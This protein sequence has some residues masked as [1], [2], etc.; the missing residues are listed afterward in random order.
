MVKKSQTTCSL[1]F[2]LIRES[3]VSYR[4]KIYPLKITAVKILNTFSPI[5]YQLQSRDYFHVAGFRKNV[6]WIKLLGISKK[7]YL[8]RLMASKAKLKCLY[9]AVL[10]YIEACLPFN[11]M[12]IATLNFISYINE[13]VKND[14][15]G[16]F[17]HFKRNI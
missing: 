16:G 1:H 8:W 3:I 13:G 12:V 5:W 6:N 2:D 4:V 11:A 9:K 17:F 7:K 15:Y 10:N 14:I